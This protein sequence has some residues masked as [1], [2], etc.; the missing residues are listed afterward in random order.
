[1]HRF[2]RGGAGD[3]GSVVVGAVQVG[4]DVVAHSAVDRDVP[5]GAPVLQG[6]GLDGAYPVEGEHARSDDRSAGFEGELRHGGA[7]APALLAAGAGEVGGQGGHVDL[8]VLGQVGDAVSA[9]QVQF[10]Q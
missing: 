4:L 3:Q 8:L 2:G 5:P 6:D 7:Q 10:C 9:A 1:E